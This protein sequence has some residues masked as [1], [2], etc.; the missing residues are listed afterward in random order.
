MGCDI[1]SL[2][3][4]GPP[5]EEVVGGQG[6]YRPRGSEG[7][8]LLNVVLGVLVQPWE[9]RRGWG[10]VRGWRV[11]AQSGR[12]PVLKSEWEGL[13]RTWPE[14]RGRQRVCWTVVRKVS[15]HR[16]EQSRSRSLSWGMKAEI[17]DRRAGAGT[18]LQERKGK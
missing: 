18:P 6:S 5:P 14:I 8:H 17:G 16:A 15:G 4:C 11:A 9:G 1:F 7:W 10:R 3:G 12:T 13:D 2:R